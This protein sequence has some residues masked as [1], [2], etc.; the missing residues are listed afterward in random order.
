M[1][2]RTRSGPAGAGRRR[3]PM[4]S[5]KEQQNEQENSYRPDWAPDDHHDAFAVKVV[6]G[7]ANSVNPSLSS[8]PS[9]RKRKQPSV[10]ELV[11]GVKANDRVKLAR[12]IT[13]IESNAP[14]HHQRAQEALQRLLPDTGT[15]LRIGITGVPG[16]GKS[17]FIEALGIHLIGMGLKVAVLTVDPSSSVTRGSILGDKTRMEK[18]SREADCF[19]RPS[20]SGG[21][22]GGVARKSRETMLVCEAAGYDVILI[23]TVGVGQ[24]EIAVR[25][26]V[27]FFLLVLIPGG[28]DELQGI[29]KGIMEITDAILI[30]KADG[31]LKQ[32]AQRARAEYA[33]ALHYLQ[34]ATK[35]W[36]PDAYTA[37]ALNGEGIEELWE[38]IQKFRRETSESGVFA[39]RRKEQ[40]L[41]WVFSL[42]EESLKER[43]Y[44][45]P[46]IQSRLEDIKEKV[47]GDSLL[48]TAAAEELLA[49]YFEGSKKQQT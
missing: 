11:E 38:V 4:S 17:T 6:K 33:N 22:L 26:M 19:I 10:E 1:T 24:S 14:A 32:A 7:S 9:A 18:L 13:L 45:N 47:Y 46:E 49:L 8:N 36:R 30:N 40:S 41:H 48:P 39:K 2:K 35:G 43:F 42:V 28:G 15:S 25:S 44:T 29:K 27:D 3:I 5:K 37:S 34:P 31:Q 23:E 16:A 12:T 20:P 21:T